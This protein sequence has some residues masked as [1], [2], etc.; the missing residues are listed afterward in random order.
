MKSKT[1]WLRV[2]LHLLWIC[3]FNFSEKNTKKI[4]KKIKNTYNIIML[5]IFIFVNIYNGNN[6]TTGK[7]TDHRE[8]N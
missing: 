7:I 6:K 3:F 5:K 1:R 4:D 2:D 8:T